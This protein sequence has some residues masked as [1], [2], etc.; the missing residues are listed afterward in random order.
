MLVL[1]RSSYIFTLSPF[2]ELTLFILFRVMMACNIVPKAVF[3]IYLIYNLLL[4]TIFMFYDI[5]Y[6]LIIF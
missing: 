1:T 4:L 3:T 6:L 2:L 5:N